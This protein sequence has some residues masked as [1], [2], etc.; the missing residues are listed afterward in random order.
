MLELKLIPVRE[1]ERIRS[2]SIEESEKMALIADLCRANTFMVVKKAGSGHLGSSFSAMDI[3]VYLYY[4]EMNT[5]ALG[6]DHQDRDI[7]FSSKGHDVPG[8]Y[9]VLYSLSILSQ[10]KIL[11]LRRLGGLDGHPDVKI[12]GVEAN[13]GSLG[14]G[15]SKARGMAIAKHLKGNKGRIFVLTG[16]GELQEGQIWESLQT[17]V[18]QKMNNINVIV[19]YNKI[20]SDKPVKEINNLGNLKRKFEAFGWHVE[21][22]DGHDYAALDNIFKKFRGITDKPKIL[23]ADTVKGKGISFMEGQTALTNGNGL[24]K[25]HSGAPDDD[26]FEVGH[27]EILD[28]INDRLNKLKI[29][30]ISLEGIETREKGRERRKDVAE[31]VVSAYGDALVE[32]G[33]KRKDIVVLDADLSADCGLRPFENTFPERFIE[34]GIAE[35][36]MVSIAGGLALHGFLPI[37]NSFGVFL[38]SRANEQIYN[39]ATEGTK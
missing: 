24:Y 23:I 26:S 28:S 4:K 34:N 6:L 12:P 32:L 25:W 7:Y 11:N 36:D 39:N 33:K 19:D 31:K 27:K 18:H 35:Q 20:Q 5:I 14:M 10:E 2:S 3:V 38:A 29:K 13:S 1:F 9:S 16:D 21:R 17:T 15:I 30:P 37:V 22:C 8:F